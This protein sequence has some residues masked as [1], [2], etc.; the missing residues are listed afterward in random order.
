MTLKEQMARLAGFERTPYPVVSLY[1]DTRPDQH[2]RDQFGTFVRKELKRRAQTYTPGSVERQSLDRDV[3]RIA[4]FLETSVEPSKNSVS[5]F[6]CDAAG[7][8]EAVQLDAPLGEHWLSIGDRPHLYPLARLLDEYPRYAV[9]VAS[10]AHTRILVVAQGGIEN[11]QN[12]DGVKTRRNSQGGWSQ[13][14]FQRHIENYH[15]HHIKDVVETLE[16]IVLKE[17]LDRIVLVGD[18]VV[19]P[20]LREQIPKSLAEKVVDELAVAADAHDREVI[21]AALESVKKLDAR[22]DR[23]RV[24]AAI[25]AYRA[26]GLGVVGPDA[27]LLALTN[28]QVDELLLTASVAHLDTLKGSGAG[29]M[30]VAN[31]AG[32]IET[33]VSV[34][35]AGEA[36]R[37]DAGTV[38]V[39]D[40]LVTKAHQTNARVVFIQ[41]P[42]LLEPY[43]GVA[44]T[45]RYRI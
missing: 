41:D 8:F 39:A 36:A 1:L 35:T 17:D 26:G 45:L 20:L 33:A 16:K 7:L 40:E 37:A 44:A 43:G 42:A 12:I 21:A 13:A 29:V 3:D 38:Q 27:T 23:E 9:V 2:G 31:D 11:S 22:T 30:A 19:L 6:A 14:R 24:D 32:V 15:L 10:T 5:L 34:A 18:E 25:G 4:R 28:G